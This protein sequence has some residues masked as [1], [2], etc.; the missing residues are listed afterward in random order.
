MGR[1][2]AARQNGDEYQYLILWK[3]ILNMLET[4][5]NIKKIE[6]EKGPIGFDDIVLFFKESEYFRD[7]KNITKSYIQVKF[8]QYNNKNIDFSELIDNNFIN[9]SKSFLQR[10]KDIYI[11]KKEEYK[12]SKFVLYT[13]YSPLGELSNCIKEENNTLEIKKI[14]KKTKEL[15]KKHLEVNEKELEDIL[16]QLVI[17]KGFDY[18]KEVEFLNTRL[19]N[20]NLIKISNKTLENKYI[21]LAKNWLHNDILELNKEYIMERCKEA[22]LYISNTNKNLSELAIISFTDCAGHLK[23]ENIKRIDFSSFFE[24]GKWIKNPASWKKISE[25]IQEFIKQEKP[26]TK[27]GIHLECSYSVAFLAGCKFN[28]KSG[29]IVYPYQK[30]QNGIDLWNDTEN[31]DLVKYDDIIDEEIEKTEDE[32]FD[33]VV[34]IGMTF[35]IK[36]Q[37]LEYIKENG[38]KYSKIYNFRH[39]N[40][41]KTSIINGAQCK[42]INENIVRILNSRSKNEKNGK[43]HLF[44]SAP[45]ALIF[46]LGKQYYGI[47]KICVYEY[48]DK[49]SQYSETVNLSDIEL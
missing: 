36:T 19:E 8:H 31:S 32:N 40:P 49:T 16:L 33:S 7:K 2:I 24:S 46:S 39:K 41:T 3:S 21:D 47:G 9:S 48:N 27:Y 1:Q 5:S 11:E 37:V 13:Q 44:M 26:N 43:T 38:I 25:E 23:N 35:D 42:I 15:L 29:I 22:N 14:S 10:L 17:E 30:K 6:F 12:N 18:K 20:N 34:I 4:E 28:S 45:V